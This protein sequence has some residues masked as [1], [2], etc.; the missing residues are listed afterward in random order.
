MMSKIAVI[1][2]SK[3]G[4]TKRY[5]EWISEALN[6]P[7]FEASNIKPSQLGDYDTVIYG[8]G[9]YANG[10]DGVKLV[11]QNP[12]KALIVFTVGLADPKITDYTPIL[13]KTFSPEQLSKTKTF[14]LRGGI[15]YKKLSLIHK[16]MMAMVKKAV[17][18]KAPDK[19]TSDDIGI[20]ETYGKAVDFTDKATI[21]P[22]VDYVLGY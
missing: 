11:T 1:Y 22:L 3:Y 18:K 9:L 20:L 7:V 8:G 5:A 2:K 17:D 13:E 21:K 16:G 12:C 15:D 19:R 10:I 6:A 14:H 4:M